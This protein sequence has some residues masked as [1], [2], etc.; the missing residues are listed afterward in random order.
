MKTI[1]RPRLVRFPTHR[2]PSDARRIGEKWVQLQRLSP[3]DAAW[4]D[5]LLDSCVALA[6]KA[7]VRNATKP[8]IDIHADDDRPGA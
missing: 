6:R 4:V 8:V 7:K 1:P 3:R 2:R 5:A